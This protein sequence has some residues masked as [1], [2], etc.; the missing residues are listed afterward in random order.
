MA[1][2]NIEWE[3]IESEAMAGVNIEWE[4]IESEAMAGARYLAEVLMSAVLH[5]VVLRLR[6]FSIRLRQSPNFECQHKR[7]VNNIAQK[8]K[9]VTILSIKTSRRIQLQGEMYP[10]KLH[11]SNNWFSKRVVIGSVF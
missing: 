4:A 7:R 6:A 8:K 5:Y 10:G 2:V 3:A 9:S 11:F 1:G